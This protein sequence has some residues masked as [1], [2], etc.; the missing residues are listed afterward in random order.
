M[1]SHVPGTSLFP[2]GV[3]TLAEVTGMIRSQCTDEEVG[4]LD[5]IVTEW[6]EASRRFQELVQRESGLPET[7]AITEVDDSTQ[8]ELRE[9]ASD[10]LFRK[11]FSLL[12]FEFKMVEIGKL[13]APQRL[14]NLDYVGQLKSALPKDPSHLELVKFCLKQSQ[15]PPVPKMMQLAQNAFAFSSPSQDFR[16]LGGYPKPLDRGDVEASTGGGL[17]VAAITLL[18]G[19]GASTCN[20]FR[21]G[22][23]L[24]LNNGFHRMFALESMGVKNAP[25]LVQR[26]EN[27]DL[28]FPA[29]VAGLPKDYLLE[30]PRPVLMRD[31]VDTALIRTIHVK[32]RMMNIQIAWNS[33]QSFVPI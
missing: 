14:V 10:T 8:S 19:Y 3:A 5:T 6:R 4:N 7:I 12:P 33:Q 23:R 24:V 17:P 1:Q 9:I 15:A 22:S 2:Y 30:N 13:V 21:V 28:E 11:S 25:I 27:P 20:A 31:F 16:F 18:L 26:V 32:P 29:Q